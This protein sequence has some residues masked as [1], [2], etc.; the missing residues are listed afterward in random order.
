MTSMRS[1][2]GKIKL[3]GLF[4]SRAELNEKIKDVLEET[5]HTWGIESHRYEILR[6]EPTPDI[7]RSMQ[8]EAESE[9]LKRKE[10]ILSEASKIANINIAEGQKIS[11]ILFAEGQANVS[12]TN[13]N[14]K[15][16]EIITRREKEGLMLISETLAE[17]EEKGIASLDYMLSQ[18]YYKSYKKILRN[19]NV[20]VIPES[21]DGK[22]N[23][24]VAMMS[25]MMNMMKEAQPT[26]EPLAG[27]STS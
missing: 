22:S 4:Q 3:D 12:L 11:D 14:L 18:N 19:A 17:K 20:S 26:G 9:R 1:E 5:T 2:I 21:E 15:S 24:T 6:I 16:I 27:K 10:I 23:D 8:L 25:M 7:K 13:L